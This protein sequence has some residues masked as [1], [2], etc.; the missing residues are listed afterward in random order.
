MKQNV[1]YLT[2]KLF[3]YSATTRTGALGR[4]LSQ[5]FLKTKDSKAFCKR[6]NNIH[7]FEGCFLRGQ[8]SSN[9]FKVLNGC[10]VEPLILL[11][12]KKTFVFLLF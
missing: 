6:T 11:V 5:R 2:K 10:M 7:E 12:Y 3:L 1:L 8:V 9:G 4:T